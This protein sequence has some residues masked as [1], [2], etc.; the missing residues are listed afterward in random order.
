MKSRLLA[1]FDLEGY[2]SSYPSPARGE[3]RQVSCAQRM[4][5][6][7]VGRSINLIVIHIHIKHLHSRYALVAEDE[8]ELVDQG[9]PVERIDA[10][11]QDVVDVERRFL[12][13]LLQPRQ[14]VEITQRKPGVR[15]RQQFDDHGRT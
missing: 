1:A 3:G 9:L 4:R 6:L 5:T 13:F 10:A 11:A 14:F 7:M 15:H 12:V 8:G 2:P